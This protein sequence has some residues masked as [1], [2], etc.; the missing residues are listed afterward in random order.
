MATTANE[1]Q[2]TARAGVTKPVRAYRP[3]DKG[4]GEH[5]HSLKCIRCG[6][7]HQ[8]SLLAE[9]RVGQSA[10]WNA[11]ILL[12]CRACGLEWNYRT[13]R[14]WPDIAAPAGLIVQLP[15]PKS[16]DPALI[17]TSYVIDEPQYRKS[18]AGHMVSVEPT[19]ALTKALLRI[20]HHD[21]VIV[22]RTAQEIINH[23]KADEV[24]LTNQET[25][26]TLTQLYYLLSDT[27]PGVPRAISQ[28]PGPPPAAPRPPKAP[29][30]P[31]VISP[32]PTVPIGPRPGDKKDP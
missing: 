11:P 31:V 13:G 15:E 20:Q 18:A 29:P 26:S 4:K 1:D 2:G 21:T 17:G 23:I 28:P 8:A 30:A 14:P 25:M 6:D 19:E 16:I 5:P 22:G 27:I 10:A 12:Q 3:L 24:D 9:L 32:W 7:R